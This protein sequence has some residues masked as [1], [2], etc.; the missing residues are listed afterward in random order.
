MPDPARAQVPSPKSRPRPSPGNFAE[1]K[2][3]EVERLPVARLR[4]LRRG[5]RGDGGQE[6]DAVPPKIGNGTRASFREPHMEADSMEP[7]VRRRRVRPEIFVIVGLVFAAAAIAK[8][9]GGSRPEPAVRPSP[10]AAI[11]GVTSMP[12]APSP[13][14]PSLLAYYIDPGGAFE[15]ALNDRSGL[16]GVSWQ[17]LLSGDKHTTFGISTVSVVPYSAPQAPV[18]PSPTVSWLACPAGGTEVAIRPPLNGHIYA[19]AATWP[20]GLRVSGVKITYAP[21]TVGNLKG[22]GVEVP[23][24]AAEAVVLPY[25]SGAGVR[26]SIGS[27][28]FWVAS[29]AVRPAIS[30]AAL[31]SA[32]QVG[33][34]PWPP[35]HYVITLATKGGPVSMAVAVH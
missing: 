7:V 15:Q 8:P 26:P 28:R 12:P 20:A 19:L 30:G 18:P 13:T 6:G 29:W 10:T 4:A 24:L 1:E 22:G 17:V 33:P 16:A 27:G 3:V 25:R 21:F 9:W 31:V 35:G 32:W 14:E 2:I 23:P 34:W 5:R 11:T